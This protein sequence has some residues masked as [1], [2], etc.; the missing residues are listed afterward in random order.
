M[1]KKEAHDI[2]VHHNFWRT[3]QIEDA[4][5]KP[6]QITEAL[7]VAIVYLSDNKKIGKKILKS[8]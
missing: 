3:G 5:Y 6:S 8:N 7:N 2:L 4:K 1:T